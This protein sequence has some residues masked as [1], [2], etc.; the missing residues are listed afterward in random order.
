MAIKPLSTRQKRIIS[1]I[2]GS[3][4][5][6]GYPPTIRGIAA[7]CGISSTSVVAYNLRKLEQ[8][9]YIRRHS[10]ISRGMKFLTPRQEGGNVVSIPDEAY[11]YHSGQRRASGVGGSCDSACPIAW[12]MRDD[13]GNYLREVRFFA[14][15]L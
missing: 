12:K 4:R 6:R 3:L 1:F 15:H 14:S 13:K 8:A 10:D 9:G 2:T 11:S 5:D 7:G